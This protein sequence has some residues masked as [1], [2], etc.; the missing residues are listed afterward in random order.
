M[1]EQSHAL[2][3]NTHIEDW[4]AYTAEENLTIKPTF[5]DADDVAVE[6]RLSFN[7]EWI[8]HTKHTVTSLLISHLYK[9]KDRSN[10]H[11]LKNKL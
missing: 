2:E 7:L 6:S 10:V 11:K 4:N 9:S 1:D 8:R 5:F 3:Y